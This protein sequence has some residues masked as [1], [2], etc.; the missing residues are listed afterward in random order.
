MNLSH[1]CFE[2]RC[3]KVSLYSSE[4]L[5][6]LIW[7]HHQ[8]FFL[9]VK[10]TGKDSCN[11]LADDHQLPDTAQEPCGEERKKKRDF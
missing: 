2:G 7:A 8:P 5:P 3:E 4:C 6:L 10:N 11:V 1:G 9:S